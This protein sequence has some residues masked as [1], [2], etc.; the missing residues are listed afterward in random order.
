MN[1]NPPYLHS[2]YGMTCLF[3]GVQNYLDICQEN[4]IPLPV[5][6][7]ESLFYCFPNDICEMFDWDFQRFFDYIMKKGDFYEP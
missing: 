4:H 2:M 6:Y 1:F 3:D 7:Y 5:E